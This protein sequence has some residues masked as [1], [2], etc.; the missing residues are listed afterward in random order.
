MTEKNLQPQNKEAE[1]AVLGAMMIGKDV[2]GDI[3]T[4]INSEDFYFDLHAKIFTVIKDLY[5]ANM[6]ADVISVANKLNNDKMFEEAGKGLYLMNL[7]DTVE[8]TANAV[9]YANIVKEKAVLR[10]LLN[11]CTGIHK[12]ILDGTD[13]AKIILDFAQKVIFDVAINGIKGGFISVKDLIVPT[14]KKIEKLVANKNDVP[15]LRTHFDDFDK[16]LGG[17][18]DSELIIIAGRPSMGKTTFALNIALNVTADNTKNGV[19]IFSLEMGKES[20]MNKFV[21]NI[22][23][24]NSRKIASGYIEEQQFEKITNT[25]NKIN[26]L[27]LFIDD[28]CDMTVLDCRIESR[29]LYNKLK[30]QGIDLKLIII[31]YLQLLSGNRQKDVRALEVGEISRNLKAL[32]RDLNI[33]VVALSQLNRQTEDR[34]RKNNKPR[35]SDLRDSGSIEQD[36]DVV[37]FVHRDGYYEKQNEDI[38]N[39]ATLIIEKNRNG[40]T[41]ECPMIFRKE[42]SKFFN[43]ERHQ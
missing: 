6:P 33:P 43:K 18:A 34:G 36:A 9:H 23:E 16:R 25:M 42:I 21:S 15:H 27:N 14:M 2:V 7:I 5:I 8:T 39:D 4:L 37:V 19:A 12:K 1:K 31:D 26:N 41:C 32:A 38:Q 11:A 29:K 22:S 24:I 17:L 40:I 20:L 13:E 30:A 3:L 35:L 28:R 10:N